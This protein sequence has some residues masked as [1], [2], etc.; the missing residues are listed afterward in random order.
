MVAATA[1][2]MAPLY[3]A[4]ART[5]T[6][7]EASFGRLLDAHLDRLG[8]AH[9]S[10]VSAELAALRSRLRAALVGRRAVLARTHGDLWLG[11]V[12]FDPAAG[13]LTG[14]VDW[15]SSRDEDLPAVDIAHLVISTRC[16]A[17]GREIADV[18]GRLLD[19]EDSLE[20]AG[21]ALL[22]PYLHDRLDPRDLLLLAW[23]QHASQRVA[24]STLHNRGRWM[25]RNVDPVL[26][27]L[28][29]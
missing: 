25:R 24:Q 1:H 7:D 27:R 3:T 5:S 4:T 29:G 19:G 18:V 22:E 17:E 8:A 13:S 11:N 14:V 12:L 10:D 20:P 21:C 9:Q 26:A 6:I 15:E 23:L 16:A 28:R 2:G